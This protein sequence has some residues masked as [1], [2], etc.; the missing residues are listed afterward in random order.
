ML[1]GRRTDLSTSRLLC[2]A[3][4]SEIPRCR[5]SNSDPAHVHG[6]S[7]RMLFDEKI[8]DRY[9]TKQWQVAVR[10]SR[11]YTRKITVAASGDELNYVYVGKISTPL[12]IKVHKSR[13]RL[14]RSS[15]VLPKM[16]D[17]PTFCVT[18]NAGRIIARDFTSSAR[19]P[20]QQR[21]AAERW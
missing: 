18:S 10:E 21:P 12:E 9:D 20:R 6:A 7:Y 15:L 1:G 19:S 14:M 11:E 5:R 17:G 13:R 8:T 16:G 3:N 2:R 4:Q